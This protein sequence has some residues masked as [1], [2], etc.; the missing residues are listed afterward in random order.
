[1]EATANVLDVHDDAVHY[2]VNQEDG[3]VTKFETLPERPNRHEQPYWVVRAS[4]TKY[5]YLRNK[6]GRIAIYGV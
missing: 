5:V 3:P 4:A 1:M 6:F 2:T